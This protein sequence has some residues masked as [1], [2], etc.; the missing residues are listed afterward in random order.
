MDKGRYMDNLNRM[1]R[2]KVVENCFVLRLF[3]PDLAVSIT[4]RHAEQATQAESGANPG[5]V[6][7][8]P[9]VSGAS[10]ITRG[11]LSPG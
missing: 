11:Q 8:A 5:S 10:P 9:T 4:I 7:A 2:A 1:A 6:Q 3:M